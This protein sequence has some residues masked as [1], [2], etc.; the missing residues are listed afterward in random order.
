MDYRLTKNELM[1]TLSVWNGFLNKKVHLIACGGTALTLLGIKASTKDVD[2]LV[3]VEQEYNYLI[4]TLKELGYVS[5]TGSGWQKQVDLFIFDLY[6]GKRVH[7]TELLKS[8]MEKM[9][10]TLLKELSHLYVGILNEYDLIVSKLFRGTSVDIDDC[11]MLWRA[12][13]KEIDIDVLK[14]RFL[15]TAKYDIA[16]DRLIKSWAHYEQIF[17]K[18]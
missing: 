10:H 12:K 4:K 13:G 1:E 14:D 9:N 15:E 7:T 8:P 3:P 6:K 17:N 5:K 2:F 16:E 11:L 18:G